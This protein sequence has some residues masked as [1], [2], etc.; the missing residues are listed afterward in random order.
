MRK[1][2][3]LA[4]KGFPWL[5]NDFDEDL[6]CEIDDY[7]LRVEQMDTNYWWWLV[8]YKGKTLPTLS[9][10]TTSKYRAIGLAEGTY[11]GHSITTNK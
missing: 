11:L 10:S 5:S 7:C 4:T 1:P 9:N 6:I 3:K 8:L 2:S